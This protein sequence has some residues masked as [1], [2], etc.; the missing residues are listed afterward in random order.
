MRFRILGIA[1]LVVIL[2][3]G[4]TFLINYLLDKHRI[5]QNKILLDRIKHV[6]KLYIND[7][8]AIVYYMG[9]KHGFSPFTLCD[10]CITNDMLIIFPKKNF[11]FQS[12]T[13]PLFVTKERDGQYIFAANNKIKLLLFK[14]DAAGNHV[15]LKFKLAYSK[16]NNVEIKLARLSPEQKAALQFLV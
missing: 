1:I 8:K 7:V 6:T 16:Y 10:L 14:L 2:F 5:N 15:H 11:F 13:H 3:F 12:H 4:T 9:R